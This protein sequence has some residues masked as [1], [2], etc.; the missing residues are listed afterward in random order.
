MYSHE[1][2]ISNYVDNIYRYYLNLPPSII[3]SIEKTIGNSF[4]KISN[5]IVFITGKIVSSFIGLLTSIPYILMLILFTLLSTYFFTKDITKHNNKI[6]KIIFN[7][8]S[9]KF[10]HIYLEVKRC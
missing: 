2:E 7:E 4:S 8:H 9:S 10:S 6:S 3:D 1:E 5:I